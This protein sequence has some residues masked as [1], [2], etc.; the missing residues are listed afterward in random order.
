MLNEAKNLIE[1]IIKQNS[2]IQYKNLSG[3]RFFEDLEFDS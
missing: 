3:K 1:E 2:C